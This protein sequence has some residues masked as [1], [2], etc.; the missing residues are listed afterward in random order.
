MYILYKEDFTDFKLEEFPYDHNHSALGEYHTITFP[1]YTGDFY[2]PIQNHQWRSQGGSWIISNID[3]KR[4]LRQN[5]GDYTKGHY[6]DVFSM[7][8]FKNDIYGPYTL[9][10]V[11]RLLNT[12]FGGG[13]AFNYITSRHYDSLLF[14]GKSIKLIHKNQN[15]EI[16]LKEVPFLLDEY[17]YYNV[18]IEVGE[19]V[20]VYIDD[21][22]IMET[23]IVF[24]QRGRCGV[25]SKVSALYTDILVSIKD[26][27]YITYLSLK[28]QYENNILKKREKYSPLKLL[29]II[30]IS[31]G[32][33]GRQIRFGH[34]ADGSMFF[35]LAQHQKLIMRDSF[36]QISCLTAY[37]FKGNLLWQKGENN[38][39]NDNTLISCDLPFQ[40][41]DINNDG[42][43]E[44]IYSMDFYIIICVAETGEEIKR[45][46]TP[47]TD[48]LMK[49]RPYKRL[50]V[51][52]IRVA[53]FEG[54]G[55]K[56]D[57][58][59]KDRYEN[60]FAFDHN[61]KLMFRYHLKNTGHF[62]YIYDFNGDSYDEMFVGYS[63]VDHEGNILWS[64]PIE[65]D[66]TDEIIYASLKKGDKKR[67]YLASGNE[68]FNVVNLDGTIYKHNEVGHAQ[69]IAIADYNNDGDN[70]VCVT[71]FWG[72]NNICYMFDS[73]LNKVK[74]Y[75]F[76][77][78]GIIISP[79]SYDGEN[80]LLIGNSLEGLLDYDLDRVVEFPND[81]HPNLCQEAIDIDND[82]ISE[83][84]CWDQHKMYI[85]KASNYKT[86]NN[87][88]ETY[89]LDSM[90]NYRGE[91]LTKKEEKTFTFKNV[92]KK[93]F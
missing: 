43:D 9:Q 13:F 14:F 68:G 58:I 39:S 61:M 1:G 70:E 28:D 32:G 19:K 4:Y 83:I 49:D 8:I 79:V 60:V 7:L 75:E 16:I 64:M 6:C 71:S 52:A 33:S 81:N 87:K 92:L 56:G 86:C 41:A 3:G 51:D 35:I 10:G 40:I 17:R 20:R 53:D 88:Y 91:F 37:D 54:L 15:E 59:V 36:A 84:L 90:S 55:Y 2:D 82:G 77:T 29:N 25:L 65:S 34:K 89:P 76:E 21:K 80:V 24:N 45:V 73:N 47:L 46:K 78:N 18:K 57:M 22:L 27:D 93:A 67:L 85:Y 5:R 23:D 74:E 50:N 12:N 31:N 26:D 44:L 42:I 69:R 63:Y 66:H 11:I 30:D 72:A 38:N 62:P 48:N